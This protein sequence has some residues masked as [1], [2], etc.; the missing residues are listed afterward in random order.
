MKRPSI[1]SRRHLDAVVALFLIAAFLFVSPFVRV[2]AS[3]SSPWYLPYLLWLG[4]II[5]A[6]IVHAFRDDHEL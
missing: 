4:V 6:G 2:W 5:L 1:D 3:D